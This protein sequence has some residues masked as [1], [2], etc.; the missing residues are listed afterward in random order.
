MSD[1]E[2]EISR[3]AALQR[4]AAAGAGL[5]A[6]G[7]MLASGGSQQVSG[8]VVGP[9]TQED[10]FTERAYSLSGNKVLGNG[11]EGSI[12]DASLASRIYMPESAK[13]VVRLV[14]SLPPTTPIAIIGGAHESSNVAMLASENAVIFD[15]AKLNSIDVKRKDN[16]LLFTVGAGVLFRQLVETV[17]DHQGALPVGTGPDVGVVGYVLNGGISG[18]FSRRLGLL[19][20]RVVQMT[21]VTATGELRVVTPQDELFAAMLGAGSALAIVV[22]MTIRVAPESI[23]Q[24]AEQRV[25]GFDTRDQAVKFSRGALQFMK[26]RALPNDSVSMELVVSG[27]K[28]LVV[29]VVFY[30]SFAGDAKTYIKPL[31]D[32]STQLGLPTVA[33]ATWTTWY[34]AAA[35][36]WPVISEIVGD[37]LVTLQHSVGTVGVPSDEILDF[38]SD[39]IVAEF[40]LDKA[41]FSI[42]EI[43]TLG[44]AIFAGSKIPTGNL[45]HLFFVD[46]I[47]L[48]DAK[49][50][51]VAQRQ[52]IAD[53]TMQVLEKSAAVEGLAID[54]SGTHSQP[55]DRQT[56]TKPPVMFGTKNSA[57]AV[58]ALK[59]KMDPSN[60]FR[61]HPFTKLL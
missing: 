60:R 39:T 41:V 7:G 3:R 59:T 51:T 14:K 8:S 10:W 12:P 31:T 15:M 58:K 53:S 25:F 29:N 50:K 4:A 24:G 9:K 52:A 28:A 35:A 42:I 57:A 21:V 40:P 56:F 26:K 61:F 20:Q 22:D 1:S 30:D 18:Y 34:E 55:D 38:V 33:Q 36:L 11:E 13:E 5:A 17:R 19:G 2:H 23:I 44:G 46:F 43:R 48:Y 37:P 54:F 49:N 45:H 32:L 47:T 27:S 6:G 16:E